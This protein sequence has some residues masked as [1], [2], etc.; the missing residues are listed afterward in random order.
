MPAEDIPAK[1]HHLRV[2]TDLSGV[3]N[4]F[5]DISGVVIGLHPTSTKEKPHYHVWLEVDE[6]RTA[7]TIR[8]IMKRAKVK[9][10]GNGSY[11][12]RT[13]RDFHNWIN[14]VFCSCKGATEVLYTSSRIRPELPYSCDDCLKTKSLVYSDNIPGAPV[15]VTQKAPSK[16][17]LAMRIQFIDYCKSIGWKQNEH[18]TSEKYDNVHRIL[19]EASDTCTDFWENAFHLTEG[20]RMVR[21]A[22]YYFGDD[23]IKRILR[24]KNEAQFF[25][26]IFG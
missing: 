8:N 25:N 24:Q 16:K 10:F 13:H 22:I 6:E 5:K 4:C 2:T 20:E 18:F 26:R 21:H 9:I 19:K 15:V 7:Q 3:L 12:I 11:S 1:C 17:R 23:T 14:Y